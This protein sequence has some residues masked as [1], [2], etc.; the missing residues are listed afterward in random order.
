MVSLRHQLL[1]LHVSTKLRQENWTVTCWLLAVCQELTFCSH[2]LKLNLMLQRGFPGGSV[3][4]NLPASAGDVGL[5]PGMG[6]SSGEGMATHSS[7]S[8][9]NPKDKGA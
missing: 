6:K 2:F 8:M 5:T 1:P 3:V 7:I 9:G 4:K